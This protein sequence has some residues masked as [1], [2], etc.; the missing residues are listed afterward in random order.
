M[1]TRV[2]L[3]VVRGEL[4]VKGWIYSRTSTPIHYWITLLMAIIG[5]TLTLGIALILAFG[6][7][8]GWQF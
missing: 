5:T 8:Q 2:Y 7:L 3:L 4:N 6:F 1:T